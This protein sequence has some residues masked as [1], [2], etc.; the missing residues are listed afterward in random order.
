MG[1][2]VEKLEQEAEQEDAEQQEQQEQHEE[3][4]EGFQSREQW[5]ESGKNPDDWRS[6]KTFADFN[7][8][9]EANKRLHQKVD[10]LNQSF[11]QRMQGMNTMHQAQLITQANELNAQKKDAIEDAD[12]DKVN[13]IDQQLNGINQ[14]Q[15]ALNQPQDQ[16]VNNFVT[17][18]STQEASLIAKYP[19]KALDIQDKR[20][21]MLTRHNDLNAFAA[22]WDA[23]EKTFA[24]TTNH[25][26]NEATKTA[27]GGSKTKGKLS[28]T[29]C[30]P[31]EA[32]ERQ[33]FPD[34]KAGD[35]AFL[36]AVQDVRGE[37]K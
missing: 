36:Q 21:A 13:Q 37:K 32:N 3:L 16:S 34:G 24:P 26:R 8:L 27:T 29:D 25:R 2:P 10:H 14:Q 6:P 18:L 5:E 11:D 28:M 7:N 4:P 30:T 1:E 23:Y 33:W 35:K 9:T 31:E 15:T 19:A 12:V 22:E 20:Q 17:W